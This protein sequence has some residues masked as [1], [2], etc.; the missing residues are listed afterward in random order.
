MLCRAVDLFSELKALLASASK[1]ASQP[2]LSKADLM[3][4]TAASIPDICPPHIW[5]Q[6]EACWISGLTTLRTAL[7]TILRAVSPIPIGRTPG[8]LSSAIRRQE[9]KEETDLGST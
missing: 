5:R 1:T 6:P 3:A 8:H 9:R 2:S 4:W 7:A